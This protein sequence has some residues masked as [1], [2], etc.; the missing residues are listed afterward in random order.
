MIQ[1]LFCLS[2]TIDDFIPW[3]V[4]AGLLLDETDESLG[5]YSFVT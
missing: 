4:F 1:F 5:G 3:N 2:I